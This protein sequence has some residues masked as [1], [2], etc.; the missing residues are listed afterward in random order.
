MLRI[1][2][3][4]SSFIIRLA[5]FSS[6]DLIPIHIECSEEAWVIITIFTLPLD[7]HSNNLLEYPGIPIIPLP[8]SVINEISSICEIPLI[9]E[10]L[11]FDFIPITE[12]SSLGLNVFLMFIGIFFEIKGCIVGGYITL[13]PK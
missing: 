1:S 10:N 3:S 12:P 7:K 9:A 2:L 5:F 8:S 11:L 13:A 6:D 4:N